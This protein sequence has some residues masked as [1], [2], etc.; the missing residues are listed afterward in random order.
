MMI[1]ILSGSEQVQGHVPDREARSQ[2]N[3]APNQRPAG[4]LGLT[5]LLLKPSDLS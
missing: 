2:S 3:D 5:F 1:S 4:N